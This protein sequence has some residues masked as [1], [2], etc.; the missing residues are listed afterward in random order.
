MVA[1]AL[2]WVI[3]AAIL[4]LLSRSR[5]NFSSDGFT[6]CGHM[7]APLPSGALHTESKVSY[8][9]WACPC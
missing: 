2:A 1:V 7:S 4:G 8:R 3:A 6:T 9:C 5:L